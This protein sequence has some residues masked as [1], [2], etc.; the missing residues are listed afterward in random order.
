MKKTQELTRKQNLIFETIHEIIECDCINPTAYRVHAELEAEGHR[1]GTLKGTVQVIEALERKKIITRDADRQIYLVK[2]EMFRDHANIFSIPA[3]GLASCGE[4]L[5]F[6]DNNVDGYVQV[7]ASLFRKEKPAQLF[8]V[9]ALGDSMDKSGIA[10][11][12]YVVFAKYEN[13]E[14]L[15]GRIVVAVING[16]ATIKI[17]RA[18]ADG[19]I[20]LFPHSSN[21]R[22]QPIYLDRSDEILI[23]G[24]FRKVLPQHKTA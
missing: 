16:M 18:L 13:A 8:A 24:V 11:N 17:Y 9:T 22:H 6:A 5:A 19:M 21:T 3:Y 10:D 14:E 1:V 23:A 7:S 20:G 2:N 12:D 15:E 4:A